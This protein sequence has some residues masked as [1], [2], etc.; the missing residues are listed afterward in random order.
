MLG[1]ETAPSQRTH[2]SWFTTIYMTRIAPSFCKMQLSR[3]RISCL[4][5][6]PW[7]GWSWLGSCWVLAW[8]MEQKQISGAAEK[9]QPV[10][11]GI[12]SIQEELN[13]A[14][15]FQP[16]REDL[17]FRNTCFVTLG[18]IFYIELGGNQTLKKNKNLLAFKPVW[19]CF[20]S[21]R[22]AINTGFVKFSV[23]HYPY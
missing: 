10:L 14:F 4:E 11:R 5:C 22:Y 21:Q 13:L 19:T 2:K 20:S 23:I 8:E 1:L 16:N 7:L 17:A 18:T 12:V 6:L 3:K 9:L 15:L